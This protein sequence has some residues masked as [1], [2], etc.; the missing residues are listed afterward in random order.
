[1]EATGTVEPAVRVFPASLVMG[2]VA[3][4]G[5]RAGEQVRRGDLLVRLDDRALAAALAEA[6]ATVQ[7][8]EAR[9]EQTRRQYERMERL[10]A[11]GSA[12]S[13][14]YE[15]AR[16]SWQVQNALL[17][18]A[19]AQV[20][21]AQVNLGY[22]RITSPMD[23][24]VAERQVEKGDMVSPGHT[25]Y[26]LED[27]SLVKV[28]VDVPQQQAAGF[29]P[30]DEVA[31]KLDGQTEEIAAGIARILPAGDAATRTFRMEILVDNSRGDLRSGMFAR[32]RFRQGERQVLLVAHGDLIQRG[33]LN[34]VFVVDPGQ[35]VRLRWLRLGD[36]HENGHE[37]LAGLAPGERFVAAPPPELADGMAVS[38]E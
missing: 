4:I 29:S 11:R 2:R 38:P 19:G 28:L 12:T 30:G 16:A 34:G 24:W 22:T 26:T 37:V 21:A 33:A 27:L 31:I 13:K 10:Q 25:L 18:Q 5:A 32:A 23:G 15:D 9:V 6:R 3:E 7:A 14:E 20:T 36:V 8:T 35:V 1:V 17:E